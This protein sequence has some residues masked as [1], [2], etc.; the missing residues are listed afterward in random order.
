MAQHSWTPQ[1]RRRPVVLAGGSQFV[2]DQVARA[3]AAA[4]VQPVF[5]GTLTEA[6]SL[7]PLVLLAGQEQPAESLPG[8]HEVIVVGSAEDEAR[9]WACAAALAS[10][11]VV[12]LPQGAGWLAEHLGRRLAPAATGSVVGLL[13]AV[14][15]C[16]VSTLAAWCA[17][18]SAQHR[19]PTL[20]VD[21]Q[22]HAG[23]LELALGI[24]DRAG[25]RWHDL[26]DIRGTLNAEQLVAALP[27]A[28]DL[29]VL[30]HAS[31]PAGVTVDPTGGMGSAAAVLD[32]ARS[33]FDLT[34]IDLGTPG[35]Q[36][37]L[38]SACDRLVLLIPSRPRGVAAARSVLRLHS[39]LSVLSVLRGPVSDG[40]DA[41]LVADLIG[42][43]AP[44][45]Y[46]PSVRGAAATEAAGQLLD[47]GLPRRA[48][49]LLAAIH[50][51]LEVAP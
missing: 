27:S 14:G 28:G 49:K 19:R 34:F 48:R 15:G 24:E 39:S 5:C 35:T 42:A 40:L 2:Q 9:A 4:G 33:A 51:H 8:Q 16:G 31:E 50:S 46:L 18:F 1:E 7:D 32:A 6:L 43:S 47:E 37:G 41:W 26:D 22:P 11:R 3:C 36:D 10:S 20:L 13:G 38:A 21:G 29:S 25:V 44:L 30:S 17:R 23:G 45:A 12:I